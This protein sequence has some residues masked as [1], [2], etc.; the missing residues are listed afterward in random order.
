ME[1][2]LYPRAPRPTTAEEH[3]VDTL[4]SRLEQYAKHLREVSIRFDDVIRPSGKVDRACRVDVTLAQV[5][6][7]PKLS[8]EGRAPNERDAADV[9]ADGVEGAVR[10]EVEE[11]ERRRSKN[12]KRKGAKIR[13]KR[14][15]GHERFLEVRRGEEAPAEGFSEV[16]IL[17]EQARE[18]RHATP[19]AVKTARPMRGRHIHKTQRQARATS[20]REV[21]ATRPSRKSTRRSANRVKRDS[22]LARQTKR[23]VRSP[24]QRAEAAQARAARA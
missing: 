24:E 16:D 20:A 6:D 23:A 13:A 14:A 12:A 17:E 11:A 5:V 4:R 10:R 1:I 9:A 22:N 3:A 18:G 21:S 19:H 8:V 7:A 15:A 2:R